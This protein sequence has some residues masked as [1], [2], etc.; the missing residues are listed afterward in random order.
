M[1]EV[2]GDDVCWIFD[3]GGCSAKRYEGFPMRLYGL[4]EK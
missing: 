1:R 4:F 3:E 2:G